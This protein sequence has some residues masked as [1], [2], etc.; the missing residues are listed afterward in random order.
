MEAD[1]I[2]LGTGGSSLGDFD[3]QFHV[4]LQWGQPI[5]DPLFVGVLDDV[6]LDLDQLGVSLSSIEF[7]DWRLADKR[8]HARKCSRH[9][10]IWDA[11][12]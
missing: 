11:A 12:L 8:P 2:V 9:T 7:V 6:L 10:G 3:D 5:A 4:D 1:V